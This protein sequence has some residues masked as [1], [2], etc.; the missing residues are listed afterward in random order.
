[1]VQRIARILDNLTV[2]VG[3]ELL[4]AAQA[5]DLRQRLGSERLSLGK[6]TQLLHTAF[7][8]VVPFLSESRVLTDD[9]EKASRFIKENRAMQAVAAGSA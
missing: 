1:V 3:M 9:I 8:Q 5:I 6:A 7:R 4:H 2:I